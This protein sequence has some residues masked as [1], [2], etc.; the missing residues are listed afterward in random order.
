M[1]M[2][3][4]PSTGTNLFS[5]L[6]ARTNVLR[7]FHWLSEGHTHSSG[8]HNVILLYAV[9]VTVTTL[10]RQ[11]LFRHTS[12]VHNW[13]QRHYSI[14]LTK[15]LVLYWSLYLLLIL[16]ICTDHD[17]LRT[18]KAY[19]IPAATVVITSLEMPLLHRVLVCR[20]WSSHPPSSNSPIFSLTAENPV[21][22]AWIILNL[23]SDMQF[24]RE[25]RIQEKGDLTEVKKRMHYYLLT[26]VAERCFRVL[27]DG[28]PCV[29]L[30]SGRR[31]CDNRWRSFHSG[32][33]PAML[34]SHLSF[35]W[36][37]GEQ[38]LA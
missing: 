4:F 9:S 10:P 1:G 16:F 2:W 11:N 13:D 35:A 26:E 27:P 19:N 12:P 24:N 6:P 34:E 25:Q 32:K 28:H 18:E 30:S 23:F 29:P 33:I 8:I 5:L 15:S 37:L 7:S 36:Q 22:L 21:C 3:D 17:A 31:L 14:N 20:S 38:S